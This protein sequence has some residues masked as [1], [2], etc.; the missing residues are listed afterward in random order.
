MKQIAFIGLGIMGKPMAKNLL[1]AGYLLKVYDI[2]R[3]AVDELVQAGAKGCASIREAVEG[4][5]VIV[6]MLPN[7]PHV[8]DVVLGQGGVLENVSEGTIV[9]DNS[10]IAPAASQQIA[11]ACLDRGVTY[12]DCPV[13]GGEPKAVDGTLAIMCGGPEEAFEKVQPILSAMAAS[14][15]RVGEVGSGN[16]AK[17]AN[18]VMV[19]V[20]IC[21]MVEALMLSVKAGVDPE[22]VYQA[23]RGG[24][25]GSTVLDAKAPMV[26]SRN[27]K[28]G[29]RIDLHI[30][31]LMNVMDTAHEYGAP[32][33]MS[34]QILEMMQALKVGGS[35]Q[36][37]HD[38]L[39]LYYE[40]L[41]GAE[42]R[43]PD[44][45]G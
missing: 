16:V 6:T 18:Q 27:F 17:L 10:S 45:K 35:G 9:V 1:K 38:A 26:L 39:A 44:A 14:V 29:F 13:S 4:A 20:N 41:A 2:V 11:K 30:K 36:C 24:L 40:K 12:L 3:P 33:P 32:S 22:R 37:D 23:V 25:A 8:M 15:V 7:S 19:A 21:G 31:D 28:P 5:E 43:R 34:A 42:I